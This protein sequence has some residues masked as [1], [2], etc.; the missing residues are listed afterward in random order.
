M[1]FISQYVC[2]HKAISNTSSNF[3][4]GT[5]GTS[6]GL[7]FLAFM[8]A[9][10]CKTSLLSNPWRTWAFKPRFSWLTVVFGYANKLTTTPNPL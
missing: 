9:I 8:Q 3:L 10:A 5:S 6:F 2:V 4:D 7:E 1:L